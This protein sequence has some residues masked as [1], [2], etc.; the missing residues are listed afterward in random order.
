METLAPAELSQYELERGKPMPSLK[1]ARIQKKLLR[2]LEQ[3]LGASYEVL[4]ELKIILDERSAV[5]DVAVFK[6]ANLPVTQTGPDFIAVSNIPI[7]AIEILSPT[8]VIA[9]LL[10]KSRRY[11][12]AG[13]KSYWLVLPELRGIAVYSELGKY[14]Y[15]YNGQTLTDPAT[16]IEMAV[17]PLFD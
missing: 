8:Q 2:I 4:P 1:H 14:K 9:E 13:V 6:Q 15:F 17:S 10:E 5:P 16:G 11:F 3:G 7:T 12:A